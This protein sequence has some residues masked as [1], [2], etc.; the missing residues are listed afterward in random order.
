MEQWT[1]PDG[2]EYV[3]LSAPNIEILSGFSCARKYA[4]SE[5]LLHLRPFNIG[6]DGE[7]D[8]SER[9]YIP[10]YFITNASDY[11]IKIGDILFNNTNSVELVGKSAISRTN[12][13]CGFSNH[14][15]RIRIVDKNY[16]DP[17]WVLVFLRYLWQ[18]GFFA[19]NCNR[20][21]GQAGYAPTKLVELQIPRPPIDEQQRIVARLEAALSEVRA[22]RELVQ[23]MQR[24]LAQVMESALAE[25][26]PSQGQTLP[27]G[28]GW[29]R[30]GDECQTTSGGTPRRNNP[31]YFGGTKHWVKSGELNDGLITTTEEYL[32]EAGLENSNAKV[33]P[34]GTLLM[35]MYGATVGKLGILEIEA[36]TNQAI[37]A[38]FTPAH[39]LTKYLFWF[40]FFARDSIVKQSFGGAQPNISQVVIRNLLIPIP[41]PDD[42][43][44]SLAEQRR[45]VARLGGIQEEVRAARE[46]LAQDEQR[47]EQLEQ[48]ILAA[49][50]RGEL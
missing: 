20:W 41:Y 34:K 15:T 3:N 39:I 33:F 29:K 50:F 9:I 10:E 46:L 42:P 28:W 4:I 13:K 44:R 23:Q 19:A 7:L 2:W 8:F 37:C 30:L 11:S 16:L 22:M 1:L 25:V 6:N 36:T 21:I 12:L 17:R 49:A 47:I 24:N 35:A 27:E 45:I 14:L 48:S 26:F 5:G 32:T 43:I 38:I 40:L 18:T 31:D